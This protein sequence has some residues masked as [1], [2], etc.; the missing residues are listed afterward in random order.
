MENQDNHSNYRV[1]LTVFAIMSLCLYFYPTKASA[2][3][4]TPTRFEI[5]GNP[6][7]TLSEEMLLI[8]EGD[9][10]EI[11][12]R[13]KDPEGQPLTYKINDKNFKQ[14]GNLFTWQTAYDDGGDDHVI[15]NVR[16]TVSD[17]TNE[18][19]QDLKVTVNNVNR[20]PV[21]KFG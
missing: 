18:V 14:E 6:G 16:V 5:R 2:L 13:A 15:Y 21:F 3:T 8:N 11:L 19:S 9:K 1:L 7:E 10:V 12:A 4:L 17:G 20:V